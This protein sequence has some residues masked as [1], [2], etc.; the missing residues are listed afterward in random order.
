[1]A[2]GEILMEYVC[3]CV[4]VCNSHVYVNVWIEFDM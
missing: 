4:C 1:M 3:V 2:S